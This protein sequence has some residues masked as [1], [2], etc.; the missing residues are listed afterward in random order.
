[1]VETT[2]ITT[3]A[4][5][6]GM[7]SIMAAIPLICMLD[8]KYREV[9]N[10]IWVILMLVN[11]PCVIVLYLNGL[12][13]SYAALTIG[14]VGLYCLMWAKGWIGGADAKFLSV[15]AIAIPLAQFSF[16]IYL[17]CILG[18]LPLAVAIRNRLKGEIKPFFEMF[19]YYPRGVPYMIPISL[20]FIITV[21]MGG[22]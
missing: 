1:M 18:F 19:S 6:F 10:I 12:P 7:A 16:Y 9:P 11:V 20:A 13:I 22:W 5:Y 8:V 2:D 17:A 21:I 3:I 14:L 15:I 4:Y